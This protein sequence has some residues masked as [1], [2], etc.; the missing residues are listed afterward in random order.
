MPNVPTAIIDVDALRHNIEIVR[1]R[2]PD[3]RIMAVIKANAYGHGYEILENGMSDADAFGVARVEEAIELRQMGIRKP[4]TVLEGF[5]DSEELGALSHYNLETVF[6]CRYQFDRI[7]SLVDYPAVKGW[8]KID[9]GMNRLGLNREEFEEVMSRGHERLDL[10]GIM[11]HFARADELDCDMT[12]RQMTCFDEMV[13]GYD[14]PVSLA[15]SAGILGWPEAHR[16]WVR[17]GIM[18]YGVSPFPSL[19]R[20]ADL[21]PAMTLLAP[22]IAVKEVKAGETVGYGGQWRAPRDTRIAIL[23]IGYGDGY[24]RDLPSGTPV[25]LDGQRREIVGRISMDMTCVELEQDDRVQAG[26]VATMWGE[27]LTVEE[28]ANRVGT[29]PYTLITGLTSRVKRK[30]C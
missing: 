7:A 14:Y 11:S 5:S 10:V 20:P 23:S 27:G 1:T 17:P 15:N 3:S 25:I 6:H 26:G 2:A 9:T 22:I 29:I 24:P 8:I 30:Y 28:L 4:I 19:E 12:R 21:R 16:D 13:A 18:L